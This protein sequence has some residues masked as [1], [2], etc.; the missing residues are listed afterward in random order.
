MATKLISPYFI[1][2]ELMLQL[3]ARQPQGPT[4][5]AKGHTGERMKFDVLYAQ[6]GI[7]A[8]D[9]HLYLRW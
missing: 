6:E 2:S 5:K 1:L 3:T 4:T 9:S 7:S 8:L